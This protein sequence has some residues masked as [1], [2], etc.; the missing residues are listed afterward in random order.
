MQPHLHR[1]L[2]LKVPVHHL[3]LSSL[4]GL[5]GSAGE[6]LQHTTHVAITTRM[7]CYQKEDE[8]DKSCQNSST[9]LPNSSLSTALNMPIRSLIMSIPRGQRR[10]FYW[11]HNCVFELATLNSLKEFHGTSL[12]KI[13]LRTFQKPSS[14]YPTPVQIIMHLTS[15]RASPIDSSHDYRWFGRLIAYNPQTL[16]VLQT[17]RRS[18][19]AYPTKSVINNASLDAT[20]KDL[21][22]TIEEE[23]KA[24]GRD[25]E[26]TLQLISLGLYGLAFDRIIQ[27]E[28]RCI[29]KLSKVRILSLASCSGVS[30]GVSSI[31][32][33]TPGLSHGETLS[34]LSSLKF[35]KMRQE[36]CTLW[37]QLCLEQ[38]YLRSGGS[39]RDQYYG[40]KD[41]LRDRGKR[42]SRQLQA[43]SD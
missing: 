19:L 13:L 6:G 12:A 29:I 28:G 33:V 23:M 30:G 20:T 18:E 4:E 2:Q 32:Q 9:Y 15:L 37:F 40:T 42:L 1:T 43:V 22:I 11:L 39:I 14:H 17:D 27:G 34:K 10:W 41:G 31:I 16:R 3:C 21:L 24:C 26:V 8:G 35:F 36:G 5:L 7:T 25:P 38:L